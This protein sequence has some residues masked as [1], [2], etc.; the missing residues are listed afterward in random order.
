[1]TAQDTLQPVSI[2]NLNEVVYQLLREC[3]LNYELLPGQRLDLVD[4][5][6]RLQLSRTPLKIALGRL[7]VEGLIEI[8]PRRGTFVASVDAQKLD[9]A[10]K[11]RSAYELYV[12]LCLF[13]YLN[14]ED[15]AFFDRLRQQM[16][17]LAEQG[18]WQA[19]ALE[20]LQLDRQL[21]ERFV[22]RGG[23]SRMAQLHQQTNVHTYLRAVI[24][25]LSERDFEA[26]HFEHEQIFDALDSQ[27]SDRLNASLLNHLE[28]ARLRCCKALSRETA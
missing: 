8:H 10:F 15:Y 21:H 12:A 17:D 1:L 27:S 9:E 22:L 4:L 16:N 20:Y 11:V 2:P 14:D 3:I 28:S 13:K 25:Y 19:V 6:N 7:E 23:P 18:D 5:E 26:I 24:P